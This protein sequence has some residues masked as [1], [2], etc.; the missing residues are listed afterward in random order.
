[1]KKLHF[2]IALFVFFQ[3]VPHNSYAGNAVL[4]GW[5]NLGMH[6]MDSRYGEFAILPPYN[7]LDAQ[8]IVNGKLVTTSST[9]SANQYTITYEA[10]GDPITHILNTTSKNKSDW[11]T[12]APTLF[13]LPTPYLGDMGLAGC[14]MPGID[15]PYVLN[16]PQPLGFEPAKAPPKS[17]QAEGIPITPYDDNG[18]KNTYP[19]MRI[20]AKDSANTVIAQSDVVL[21]V[22]DEMSCKNCHAANTNTQ[23]KPNSGWISDYIL[24]REYRLNILKLHDEKEFAR[25]SAIYS[26][27]LSAKGVNSNGLYAS[28]MDT[29]PKPVLCASCHASEALGT[30]SF[31]ATP[32]LTTS[33]H[34]THANVTAPGSN[35][36]L[37]NVTN[38]SACYE[39]HPGSETRC[40]R[41]AMG[42]AVAADGSMDMQCQSC[43]GNMSKVGANTRTGWL[44][45]PACQSCHTGTA[46]NNNGKIRYN[47]VFNNP[48]IFD[49]ERVAIDQTFATNSDTPATGLSLYR[50][51]KGHGE[52]QCSA[53]HGS[54]H[55]EFP[56]AHQNDNIRNEQLQGHAGVTVECKTCHTTGVPTTVNGGP[57]G[58]HPLDQNWVNSHHDAIGQVGLAYCQ[59]CHGSDYRGTE[60]SRFQGDRTFNV[61]DSGTQKYY[62]GGT[63][64]CY[65]C[66]NGPNSSNMN[67]ISAPTTADI[68]GTTTMDNPVD[69]VLPG[70]VNGVTLRILKQPQNGTVGIKEGVATYYPFTGYTGTDTFLFSGYD[71]NKNTTTT[72]NNKGA[73][74]ATGSITVTQP[75]GTIPS[76]VVVTVNG[77]IIDV[78][79]AASQQSVQGTPINFSVTS[80]AAS[81][82]QW[83]K[84]GWPIA[85]ATNA[86]YVINTPTANDEGKYVVLVSNAAGAVA[87]KFPVVLT[88]LVPPSIT[89]QPISQTVTA[90]V[91]I[92]LTITATGTSPLSYQWSKN[93]TSISG[94]N[95][96]T[97]RLSNVTLAS[98]GNYQVRVSNSAGFVD[99]TIAILSVQQPPKISSQPNNQ[100]VLQGASVTLSVTATGNPAV[101]Y[102]WYKNLT[103][104]AGAANSSLTIPSVA[105]GDAGTYYVV[106]SNSLGT[107][108]SNNA[109]LTVK[110]T[111]TTTI[112][113]SLNP[114]TSGNSVIFTAT[115]SGNVP[116][117]T[118]TF[119]DGAA[120]LGTGIL[121]GGVA[122][123][124]TSALASGTHSITASYPG[125]ANN[126][127]SVSAGLSQI[128][129]KA[130]TVT[131]LISNLNP[132]IKGQTVQL[133]ATIAGGVNP[134]G[135]V[136]FKDGA[137]T[138][139]TAVVT[140]GVAI[141][142]STALI[143]GSHS[144]TANYPGDINNSASVSA[145]LNQIVNKT[146]TVTTLSSSLNPSIKGQ[147]IKLTATI[148]GG[149][150]PTGSVTFTE[151]ATTLGTG[152][153]S[154]GVAS[155]S[156]SALIAG[157]HSI[158]ATYSGDTNNA[159]SSGVLSQ[160]VN[161]ATTTTVLSSSLNPATKGKTVTLTAT[162]NGGVAPTGTITFRDGATTLGT[163]VVASNRATYKT[164]T[165]AVGTHS[166][167]ASYPGDANNTSSVSGLLSQVVK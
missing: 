50:F 113:S 32:A 124:T 75:T 111:S 146:A 26:Q 65:T 76:N 117:G 98:A 12:F 61:G 21:P 38:R 9:P 41:G 139:G 148:T 128:V 53:C 18:N 88:V 46:T 23:A 152:T 131:S 27:A 11:A 1:M 58:L 87:S 145:A 141:Y 161:K 3:L 101:T 99:S 121:S 157:T 48:L 62:R 80:T 133:T 72:T 150:S 68:S 25:N 51:S 43:H 74:A 137:T 64:G 92:N 70:N 66:H 19:M 118:I 143:A 34:T 4:L 16:T 69:L 54:T 33:M 5:N 49:A 94:A 108:T 90:G 82:Y 130:V 97:L 52:L 106:V 55:A 164:T 86:S 13:G 7:T 96:N 63:V 136:T 85:G 59:S 89:V 116:A 6:C 142:N 36:S 37:D 123:Y 112:T 122:T 115:T 42:N 24:D 91:N 71:G 67:T 79:N 166:I 132:S 125:D 147:S 159:A 105:I 84:N 15:S 30:P 81:Q 135:T 8:L 104:I 109:I 154:N 126:T 110:T 153:V 140:N 107:V 151:G 155:Y 167:S 78:N 134:T 56:S 31:G 162:I 28:V 73:V 57:H 100:S 165:L 29:P 17:F 163:G 2:L 119:K 60:L 77:V 20:V 14:N 127:A 138:L 160:V 120:T 144:I 39:C 22:S 156:T 129:N 40:L 47:S 10:I 95:S 114:S 44:Q 103:L 35:L 45:E 93:G 158:T 102:Q 83:F 149:V